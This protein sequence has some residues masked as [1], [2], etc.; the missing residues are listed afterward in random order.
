MLFVQILV[1]GLKYRNTKSFLFPLLN[2]SEFLH[3]KRITFKI[4][5]SIYDISNPD[6]LLLD[7]KFFR[8]EFS[9]NFKNT[10]K[11]IENV[12]KKTNRLIYV[13]TSDSTSWIIPE[14][15]NLVDY[16][17]KSQIFK[18]KNNYKKKFYGQR[19]YTD[20]YNKKFGVTDNSEEYSQPILSEANLNKIKISWNYGLYDYSLNS[21][22][23]IFLYRL[24]KLKT[25]IKFD[26]KSFYKVQNSRTI[27]I[28]G[29]FGTE[30]TKNTV[31]YQ[32]K[33]LL[34][35]FVGKINFNKV[36]KK[37]YMEDLR[38]SV[39]TLSP[40]G[41]G[42]LCFRDF[43]AFM[44]GAIL[45]KPDMSHLDTWPNFYI[46]NSTYVPFS[47][48][49]NDISEIT[50][51]I[52]SNKDKY[53]IIAINGQNNYKKFTISDEAPYLFYQNLSKL[54]YNCV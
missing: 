36:S 18:D 53:Q 25:L 10:L 21:D 39:I 7:S 12:K 51:K 29:R 8:N 54:I 20:F 43:E 24:F 41:N 38:N 16:Y 47:W 4:I 31:G 22:L 14:V 30:Y 49:L 17:W 48:E 9:K 6:L 33:K 1:P 35:I 42:E 19:I 44:S 37:K 5:N 13:D 40:F 27:N 28:F 34:E 52:L 50:D 23:R 15:L 3:S 2:W 11:K 26:K 46:K 45:L 32:R